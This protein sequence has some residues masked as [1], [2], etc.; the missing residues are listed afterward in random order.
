M[1]DPDLIKHAGEFRRA[2]KQHRYEVTDDGGIYFSEAKAIA[3]GAYHVDGDV[4]AENIIT[5]EGLNYLLATGV[6]DATNFANWYLAPFA[7]IYTPS[8]GLT[9]A[10]FVA[11]AGEITSPTQGYSEGARPAWTSGAVADGRVDNLASRAAF[12]IVTATSLSI[13]GAGLLSSSVKGA[14]TGVLLS[15]ARFPNPVIKYDGD[16]FNLGYRLRLQAS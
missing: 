4:I 3:R 15:A 6:K 14:G 7:N 13:N 16:E 9:A 1:I 10:N 12:T 11:T 2:I 8:A 5:T